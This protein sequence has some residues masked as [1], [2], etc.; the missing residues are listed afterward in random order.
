MPREKRPS[1]A[2]FVGGVSALSGQ[3]EAPQAK[4][5][6]ADLYL[7][8]EESPTLSAASKR[9]YKCGLRSL[10][11]RTPSD[12]VAN[13]LLH[14]IG[15]FEAT[16]RIIETVDVALRTRQAWCAAVLSIYKHGVCAVAPEPSTR[17]GSR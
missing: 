5:C 17:S 12:G 6:D 7:C 2:P 16:S 13:P 14:A 15:H 4:L 11:L 9:T 10:L 1:A 3:S 8:L